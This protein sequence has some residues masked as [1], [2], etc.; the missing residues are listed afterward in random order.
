MNSFL[1]DENQMEQIDGMTTGQNVLC[2]RDT[3][4]YQ[5]YC[6]GYEKKRCFGRTGIRNISKGI[7][8]D[9]A[10]IPLPQGILYESYAVNFCL[11]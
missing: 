5:Q 9:S 11:D 3:V 10:G 8:T 1:M 7:R 4:F 2:I 6:D